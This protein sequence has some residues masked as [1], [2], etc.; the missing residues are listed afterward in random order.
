MSFL[1]IPREKEKTGIAFG[2]NQ[3]PESEYPS[4][5]V[6]RRMLGGELWLPGEMSHSEFICL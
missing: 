3:A 2:Q 4:A 5:S 1:M 6:D